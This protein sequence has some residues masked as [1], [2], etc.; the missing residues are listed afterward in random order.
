[1]EKTFK[2]AKSKDLLYS[3]K[4]KR[5]FQKSKFIS[6]KFMFKASQKFNFM[7]FPGE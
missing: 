6:I 1:M 2:I 4:F 7:E 5:V 3:P